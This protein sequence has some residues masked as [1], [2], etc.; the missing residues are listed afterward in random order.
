VLREVGAALALLESLLPSAPHADERA[1][2]A[3]QRGG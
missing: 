3:F 2:A 1:A